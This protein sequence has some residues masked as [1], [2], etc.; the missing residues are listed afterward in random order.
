MVVAVGRVAML[1]SVKRMGSPSFLFN[2]PQQEAP[3]PSPSKQK[4]LHPT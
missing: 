3:S 4:S 1:V 2:P